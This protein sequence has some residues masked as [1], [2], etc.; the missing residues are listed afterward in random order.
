MKSAEQ[1][2]EDLE[3]LWRSIS[4]PY[5]DRPASGTRGAEVVGFPLEAEDLIESDPARAG[6]RAYRRPRS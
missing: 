2:L 1:L 4:A 6:G 3:T 5:R